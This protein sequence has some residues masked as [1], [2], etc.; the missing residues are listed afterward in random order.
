M[1]AH[2]HST[3]MKGKH[4]YRSWQLLEKSHSSSTHHP[5]IQIIPPT[6]HRSLRALCIP[7]LSGRVSVVGNALLIPYDESLEGPQNAWQPLMGKEEG[8]CSP[9]GCQKCCSPSCTPP[10]MPP[11]PPHPGLPSIRV[12]S[13]AAPTVGTQP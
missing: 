8:A 11:S 6:L 1:D 4:S 3:H 7:K 10:T 9:L 5:Q 2:C 12:F 13:P